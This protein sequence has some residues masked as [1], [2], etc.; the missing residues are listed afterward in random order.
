MHLGLNL[1][2]LVPGE[3]GGMETYARELIPALLE[4]RP[5]LR[6]TAFINREAAEAGGGPWNELVP[7]VTVPVRARNRVEWVRGEQQLLPGLA[8]RAGVDVLHSLATTA[9]GWGR[10]KRITTVHDLIYRI[11]PEAHFG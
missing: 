11:L 2:Y 9:P 6:M 5:D 10:F 3:I 4:E 7:A 8:R 1:V